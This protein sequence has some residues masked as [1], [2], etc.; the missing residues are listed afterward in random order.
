MMTCTHFCPIQIPS[1]SEHEWHPFSLCCSLATHR[2][3]FIVK[4]LGSWTT[5]LHSLL[6]SGVVRRAVIVPGN[7]ECSFALTAKNPK[8]KAAQTQMKEAFSS[9]RE[10]VHYLEDA[11]VEVLGL[12]FYGCKGGAFA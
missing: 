8:V 4:D 10:E 3:E 6:D 2:A 9:S 11:A 12:R 1:I 5:Q 7:H